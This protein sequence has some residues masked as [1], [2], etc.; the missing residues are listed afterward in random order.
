ML[1]SVV[2]LTLTLT[3]IAAGWT[4]KVTSAQRTLTG[5]GAHR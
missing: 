5:G 2:V 3:G 1:R 4:E